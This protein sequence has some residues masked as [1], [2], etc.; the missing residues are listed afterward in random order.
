MSNI[1]FTSDQHFDHKNIITYC[2]RPHSD[3]WEMTEDIIE[4]FN[5]DVKDSDTTYHLG[6]FCFNPNNIKP[7][8]S[9]LRGRHILIAGNHDRCFAKKAAVQRYVE[10][11]F[12]EVHRRGLFLDAHELFLSHY[13]VSFYHEQY[14]PRYQQSIRAYPEYKT[15]HGHVHD[16]WRY[17]RNLVNVGVDQQYYAPVSLEDALQQLK[18]AEDFEPE[19]MVV[20]VRGNIQPILPEHGEF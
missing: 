19:Q 18:L 8:L 13:P 1:W 9:R 6:D 16:L 11:G 2:N 3:L 17:K 15:L 4:R 10:Y 20:N 12:V 5:L 14:N 7:I